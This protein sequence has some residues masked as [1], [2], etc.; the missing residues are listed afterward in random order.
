MNVGQVFC[1][2]VDGAHRCGKSFVIGRCPEKINNLD[3]ETRSTTFERTEV[4]L[5]RLKEVEVDTKVG[6][7]LVGDRH[8][9]YF[10][11]RHF[12]LSQ[13]QFRTNNL[14]S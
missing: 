11:I 10:L 12:N 1:L 8:K 5:I 4:I 14:S 9:S 13:L 6:K 2:L 3:W 7:S